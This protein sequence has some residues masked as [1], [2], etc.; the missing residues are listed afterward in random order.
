MKLFALGMGPGDPELVTLRACRLLQEADL[1]VVPAGVG[2]DP[3]VAE[4]LARHHGA[5]DM[6]RLRFP[7]VRSG[8]ER[9][10]LLRQQLMELAP[11]WRQTRTVAFPV[12]G[13]AALYATAAYLWDVWREMEPQLDL[14]LVPGISAHS[15]ASCALGAFLALGEE[16]LGVV[17]GSAS[18]E[19]IVQALSSMDA[20][21]LYKPS[22]LGS[23]LRDIV[24]STGPWH[25]IER[26]ERAGMAEERRFSGEQAL[27]PTDEY[28]AVL[29]LWRWR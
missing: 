10:D 2:E 7:M 3:G 11:R 23:H 6:L 28:L 8:E 9:D 25:R 19:S 26:I 13:D 27:S 14:V 24:R 15:A 1:V 21:V 22:A 29:L 18:E 4:R 12:L 17:S 16:H 5:H 20:A